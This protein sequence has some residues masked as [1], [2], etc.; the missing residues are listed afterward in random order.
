MYWTVPDHIT[1]WNAASSDWHTPHAE[2]DLRAG[3]T[4]M[5]RM[6]ARDGSMGFDLIATIVEVREPAYLRYTLED[7][8]AWDLRFDAV[9]EGTLVTERFEAEQENPREL[10]QQGWQAI[11]DR[12][13]RYAEAR[14]RE[15]RLQFREH[16][17]RTPQQVHA[18]MV[19]PDTYRQWTAEF[20]PSSRYE[21]EWSEGKSLR[22][23]GEDPAGNIGG[24]IGHIRL[25]E[26][27]VYVS[28]EHY[29]LI[30]DNT[31]IWSGPE[32]DGW[33]GAREDYHFAPEGEGTLLTVVLESTPEFESYF[34]ESWPRA[35]RKLKQVC[36]A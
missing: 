2:V 20:N 13:G 34:Q 25:N 31:E 19:A 16:I 10:Q 12:F 28:I 11:L 35:L 3:G 7:G 15:K 32:V 4:W 33:V 27:G 17:A 5:A 6:E 24:I 1:R 8:R 14:S 9:P 30:K 29:G 18:I 26:P 23:V 21:G 36:E 22:F